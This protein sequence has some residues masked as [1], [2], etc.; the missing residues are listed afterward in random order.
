MRFRSLGVFVALAL[1]LVVPS[2]YSG[3]ATLTLSPAASL[4]G[5]NNDIFLQGIGV[6]ASAGGN[7]IPPSY[8][9]LGPAIGGATGSMTLTPVGAGDQFDVRFSLSLFSDANPYVLTGSYGPSSIPVVLRINEIILDF[10]APSDPPARVGS[11]GLFGESSATVRGSLTVGPTTVPFSQTETGCCPSR[12][13]LPSGYGLD[14]VVN[15]NRVIVRHLD[16]RTDLL[17]PALRA[18]AEFERA[19]AFG[20]LG[21]AGGTAVAPGPGTAIGGFAGAAIGGSVRL[22]RGIRSGDSLL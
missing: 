7:P 15:P 22:L 14:F 12:D 6:V 5:T 4:Y 9:T 16:L 18:R 1:W 3:A 21:A 2:R 17:R 13:A 10:P 8:D 19:E 11:M 20:A